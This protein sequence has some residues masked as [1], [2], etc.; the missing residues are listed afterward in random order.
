MSPK[1]ILHL[2]DDATAGGVMRAVSHLATHPALSEDATHRILH[3]RKNSMKFGTFDA[4]VIVSHTTL[5]WRSLPGLISLRALNPSSRLI[6][7]EHSY[8]KSFTALNVKHRKR[9][10]T[11]LRLSYALFDHVVAVSQHQAD[12]LRNRDLVSA[13]SLSVIEPRVDLVPF[14]ALQKAPGNPKIIGAIGRMDR[15]KGFDILI[16]GFRNLPDP[17]ARLW[18]F[19]DGAQRQSLQARASGDTRI[20]FKGFANDPAAALKQVS[21]VAMPSRW[22]AF[23]IVALEA[24][25]AGRIVLASQTDGLCDTGRGITLLTGDNS[26][27]KWAKLLGSLLSATNPQQPLAPPQLSSGEEEWLQKWKGLFNTHAPIETSQL[28]SVQQT[29]AVQPSPMATL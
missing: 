12:W 28:S 10:F 13:R 22:E 27:K 29:S 4:D 24:A 21:I 5:S 18:L 11:M 26:P 15:Q 16:D 14:T 20:V 3:I 19:G 23:G 25:A 6:H 17:E 1:T 9:F 8:T 7:V 2:V